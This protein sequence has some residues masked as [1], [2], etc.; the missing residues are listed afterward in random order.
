VP[1][2]GASETKK[3]LEELLKAEAW[4]LLTI[5]RRAYV[6]EA[7]TTE[8]N[9]V[10]RAK[11]FEAFNDIVW[12]MLFASHDLLIIDLA[13]WGKQV[14][15]SGGLLGVLRGEF[16]GSFKRKRVRHP[17]EA[18][19][20]HLTT[21]YDAKHLEAFERLFGVGTKGNV[22]HAHFE[23]LTNRVA[24]RFAPIIDERDKRRAHPY[25]THERRTSDMI[26]TEPLREALSFGEQLIQDLQRVADVSIMNFGDLN[27]ASAKGTAKDLVDLILI[28]SSNHVAELTRKRG[29]DELYAEFHARHEAGGD[30]ESAFNSPAVRTG[31]FEE[32]MGLD[33]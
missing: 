24:A 19:R 20:R 17:S 32:A 26:Q 15:R 29:R 12:S 4:K 31:L 7:F 13:S 14:Y 10:T 8:L 23:A 5:A 25:E 1:T 18:G 22:S 11:P 6:L 9:R 2:S 21:V 3:D 28:G 33:D 27:M 16:C 30:R